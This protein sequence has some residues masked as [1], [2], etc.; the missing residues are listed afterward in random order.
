MGLCAEGPTQHAA[1]PTLPGRQ[2]GHLEGVTRR[3][4]GAG[5]GQANLTYSNSTGWRLMPMT[6]GAIQLANL[7]GSTTRPIRLAT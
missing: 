6:G 7:P 1:E 5:V 3:R 4:R 2:H